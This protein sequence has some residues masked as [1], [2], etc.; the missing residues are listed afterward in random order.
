MNLPVAISTSVFAMPVHD[1]RFVRLGDNLR[2]LL[3]QRLAAMEAIHRALSGT[4]RVALSKAVR[5][6]LGPHDGSRGWSE[7]TLRGMWM[8]FV[9]SGGDWTTL[10]NKAKAGKHYWQTLDFQ[11]MPEAFK[12]YISSEWSAN[13]RD[14]FKGFYAGRLLP[15]WKA[16]RRGD[17]SQAI[18]GYDRCPEADPKTGLPPGWTYRNLKRIA[19]DY[20]SAYSRKLIQ[21]GSK[22]AMEMAPPI[23]SSRF[24]MRSGRAI[25][26]G[27]YYLFDDSWYDFKVLFRGRAV[28]LLS[29][30]TLDLASGCNV[31]RGYKPAV[32]DENEVMEGLKAREMVFLVAALL[33]TKGYHPAGT[34]MICEKATA[35]LQTEQQQMLER[36]SNGL[37]TVKLGPA[38]G[39]PGVAGLFNGPSGGNPRWKAPIES[40]F[41]LLRNR[42][43][44]L[45]EFPGQIGSMARVNGPQ[46]H[47]KQMDMDEFMCRALQLL[48]QEK[49]ELIKFNLL[50][51][52]DALPALDAV[53]E[54]INTRNDHALEGWR[55]CGYYIA[56]IRAAEHLPWM[57]A[58]HLL[59]LPEAEQA[60][61]R[62]ML[63]SNPNLTSEI[64][65]SP[66]QVFDAGAPRLVRFTPAQC[67]LFLG[68]LSGDEQTVKQGLLAIGCAEINPDEALLFGPMVRDFN[69]VEVALQNGDKWLVRVNPFMPE[70]AFLYNAQNGFAG[71]ASAYGRADRQ[72]PEALQEAFKRKHQAVSQWTREA[73]T[74]AAPITAAAVDVV[75]TNAKVIK[76][77]QRKQLTDAQR[78][79]LAQ[80]NLA[81]SIF[82]PK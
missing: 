3:V 15:R 36:L 68:E 9:A 62:M 67:A 5:Q 47:D 4:A 25:E 57:P 7:G 71:V 29:L 60:Q 51:H 46:G 32:K 70:V 24:D 26:V 23:L 44:S 69:G 66:R 22:A 74:L 77:H 42:T 54:V 21:I 33:A 58:T 81:R 1:A 27:R 78:A 17:N 18:P 30:H 11:A 63:A 73:R 76:E 16:W 34:E 61:W 79:E 38:G 31:L 2:D 6:A 20:A 12:E 82:A 43:A 28:R 50:S 80:Q 40:W 48:P 39:G 52:W 65:L 49:A 59:N 72:D 55:K 8:R 14:K 64:A 13:Q 10:L 19:N 56:V 35:T 37:I 41:N 75:T 45:L 53:T